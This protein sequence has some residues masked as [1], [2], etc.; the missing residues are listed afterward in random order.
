M[1]HEPS[2]PAR[3]GRPKL[4]RDEDAVAAAME[5]FWRQGYRATSLDEL[6]AATGASR[7]S[8]YKTF[9]GK[10]AL[11]ARALALYADRFDER[12]E[13]LLERDAPARKLMHANL[14]AS[15]ERLTAG[16]APPGCLRCNATLELADEDE[17]LDEA[18]EAAN[19]RFTA[20]IAHIVARGVERSEIDPNEADDIATFY[21]GIVN[22]MVTLARSGADKATLDAYAD[23]AMMGW[24]DR[25]RTS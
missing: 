20:T 10:A 2:S 21:T 23:R 3:T 19:A 15:A 4:Y 17:G 5:L 7:A 16:I 8:L 6:V 14:E 9:G 1:P 13:A 18:I 22:G 24:P 12:V 11:F 25:S